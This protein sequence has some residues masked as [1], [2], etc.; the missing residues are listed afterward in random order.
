MA[1]VNIVKVDPTIDVRATLDFTHGMDV[2]GLWQAFIERPR[3]APVKI[4]DGSSSDNT[5]DFFDIA[6]KD[7]LTAFIIVDV[8][9]APIGGGEVNSG[10]TCTL[11]QGGK[12]AG[13]FQRLAKL[14][15][16]AVGLSDGIRFEKK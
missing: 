13:S 3:T 11:S 4:K 16:Q 9:L 12:A 8:K 5:A 2:F 10:Y 6:A 7:L 1:V 14:T 15:G